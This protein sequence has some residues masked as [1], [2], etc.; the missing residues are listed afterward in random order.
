M[1]EM[2]RTNKSAQQ[3][4]KSPHSRRNRSRDVPNKEAPHAMMSFPRLTYKEMLDD[5]K[6]FDFEID[7][8]SLRNPT[9]ATV[10]SV[11]VFMMHE[12]Y[13]T[14]SVSELLKPNVQEGAMGSTL[15]QWPNLIPSQSW[16]SFHYFKTVE[17]MLLDSKYMDFQSTDITSPESKRFKY[18]LCAL[19]NYAKY[20]RSRYVEYEQYLA[21]ERKM[22][23]E[24][25]NLKKNLELITEELEETLRQR[26]EDEPQIEEHKLVIQDL[27]VEHDRL[28]RQRIELTRETGTYKNDLTKEKGKLVDLQAETQKVR[29]EL[30]SN[31]QLIVHS[32]E[33]VMKEL[34]DTSRNFTRIKGT[35]AE[36]RSR[37]MTYD[38]RKK[39]LIQNMGKLKKV[40][41]LS[42]HVCGK[43]KALTSVRLQEGVV[44]NRKFAANTEY[45]DEESECRNLEKRIQGITKRRERNAQT[46]ADHTRLLAADEMNWGDEMEAIEREEA[47]AGVELGKLKQ[48]A[49]AAMKEEEKKAQLFVEEMAQ[50]D[51]VHRELVKNVEQHESQVRAVMQMF[52][53]DTKN[54]SGELEQLF[55]QT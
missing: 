9:P 51:K 20:K 48:R 36:I 17:R 15:A 14:R 55:L 1:L 22:G 35:I 6:A 4:Y 54:A 26:V 30:Q 5:L 25:D 19:L 27:I 13:S 23:L 47:A 52:E 16:A 21:K 7:E 2:R 38:S 18:Q 41:N 42:E 8:S 28:D 37:R 34:Q 11:F 32:P 46:K 33:R 53:S 12:L 39:D 43:Y 49:H 10:E 40:Q 29:G 50:A 31:K 45:H 24:Y 3:R 44:R